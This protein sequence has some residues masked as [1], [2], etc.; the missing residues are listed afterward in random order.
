M[1]CG[2]VWSCIRVGSWT[3]EAGSSTLELGAGRCLLACMISSPRD[4]VLY[5]CSAR[6]G[7]A[8]SCG[9]L[10]ALLIRR[11]VASTA[12]RWTPFAGLQNRREG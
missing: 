9:S 4:R 5:V 7:A 6:L 3:L 10:L 12:Y 8:W 1:G 11:F 2:F